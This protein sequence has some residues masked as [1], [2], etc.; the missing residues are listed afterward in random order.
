MTN[1]PHQDKQDPG[2]EEQAFLYQQQTLHRGC[3]TAADMARA[4]QEGIDHAAEM[5]KQKMRE[6]IG[7]DEKP[8]IN[9]ASNFN[10]FI[11]L[12]RL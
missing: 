11:Q 8:D 9:L 5:A 10:A 7:E 2:Q 3:Y 1:Q 4:R 12:Q 6:I